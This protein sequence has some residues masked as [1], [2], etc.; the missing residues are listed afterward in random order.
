MMW[1]ST[2]ARSMKGGG[3]LGSPGIKPATS[4]KQLGYAMLG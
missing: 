2:S 3:K 1:G 4:L